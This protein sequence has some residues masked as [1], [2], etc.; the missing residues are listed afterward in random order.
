MTISLAFRSYD[1][2]STISFTYEDGT[3][4]KRYN[5]RKSFTLFL[6]EP[7]QSGAAFEMLC[8]K[9]FLLGQKWQ[10]SSMVGVGV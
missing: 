6:P 3:I 9:R 10:V 8:R 4:V 5:G 7:P 1:S 2:K